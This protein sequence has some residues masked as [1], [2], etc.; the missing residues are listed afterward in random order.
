[1]LSLT[2]NGVTYSSIVRAALLM[3]FSTSADTVHVC[4]DKYVSNSIK[5]CERRQR[6]VSNTTFVITGPEQ[7]L[8]QSGQKVMKNGSFMNE[9]ALFFM[10]E[11][12]KPHYSIYFQNKVL[13]ASYGGN[14]LQ[15]SVD[16]DKIEVTKPPLLQGDHKEADTLMAFHASRTQGSIIVRSSDTDVMVI[17][18]ALL[19]SS[20]TK[21]MCV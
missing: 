16:G 12:K 6:D 15:Y 10:E 8:R 14:C 21:R 5:E 4:L 17:L 19:G 2:N 3:I 18:I 7:I 1:M 11:L 13:V 20:D 9:F